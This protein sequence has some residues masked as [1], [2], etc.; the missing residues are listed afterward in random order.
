MLPKTWESTLR[1]EM[2]LQWDMESLHRD[3]EDSKKICRAGSSMR[4]EG[5]PIRSEGSPMRREGPWMRFAGSP[6][7]Y[8]KPS[9]YYGGVSN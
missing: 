7:K 3:I 1:Y 2:G 6:I 5:S 9:L 8:W 4:Y